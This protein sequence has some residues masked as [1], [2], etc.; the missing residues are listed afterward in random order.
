MTEHKLPPILVEGLLRLC[1]GDFSFR[2]PRTNRRDQEDTIAFFVNT[3]AEELERILRETK[4]QEEKLARLVD[5]LSQALQDVAAGDLTVQVERD[6]SGDAA[7]VLAFLVNN[8]VT[9]LGIVVESS[10]RQ[11]A[12]EKQRL[13][14]LVAER[15]AELERLATTDALTGALNRRRLFEVAAAELARAARYE[16]AICLAM[17][18]LDHFKSINDRFGHAVGDEALHAVAEVVRAQLRTVDV[19]GRYGGEEL[20]VALPETAREP[21]AIALERIRAAVAAIQLSAEE[22]RLSISAGLVEVQRGESLDD[23]LKRADAALY[24][25]KRAG[26]NRLVVA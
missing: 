15:T 26:R 4:S 10:R 11:A 21:A 9:E 22:A 13:E 5:T 16:H 14:R 2:L 20:M 7:D 25:A 23:A 12:E 6:F 19:L 24:E 17:L 3:I 18:D 8:T 1:Q